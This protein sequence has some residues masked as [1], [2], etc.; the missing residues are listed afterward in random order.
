MLL[1][2]HYLRSKG[3]SRRRSFRYQVLTGLQLAPR[4]VSEP[5]EEYIGPVTFGSIEDQKRKEVESRSRTPR[6]SEYIA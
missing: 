5:E 3:A 6:M 2:A 4:E 1:R